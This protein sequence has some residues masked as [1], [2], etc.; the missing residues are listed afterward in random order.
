MCLRDTFLLM[1]VPA[2][3]HMHLVVKRWSTVDVATVLVDSLQTL[4]YSPMITCI[5]FKSS[6][7]RL[8]ASWGTSEKPAKNGTH[9]SPLRIQV[10][11]QHS[12]RVRANRNL[13]LSPRTIPHFPPLPGDI[14]SPSQKRSSQKHPTVNAS[15]GRL[16]AFT[17]NLLQCRGG[18]LSTL[19]GLLL[20]MTSQK[21]PWT[22]CLFP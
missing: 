2:S 9:W 18:Q 6:V 16:K 5:D 3:T 15:Y 21:R 11:L 1:A 4:K 7:E 10:Y 13:P 12:H 14:F 22:L 8:N 19:F 17:G 20:L